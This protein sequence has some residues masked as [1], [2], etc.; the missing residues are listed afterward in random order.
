MVQMLRG[1]RGGSV[2]LKLYLAII[3]IAGGGGKAPFDTSIPARAWAELLDLPDPER[4]GARRVTDAIAWLDARTMI[5]TVPQPGRPGRIILLHESGGG[6]PYPGH[7]GT[8]DDPYI[9]LPSEFWE[10]G[11]AAVLSGTAIAMLLLVL[12]WGGEERPA[13][14]SPDMA[15]RHYALS[16]DSR[17]A[18]VAELRR[19]RLIT[20]GRQLVRPDLGVS[21]MRNTYA[22]DLDRLREAPGS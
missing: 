22:A 7:P 21:R 15:A 17:T 1:G 10:Y 11:W 8:R 19:H 14:I 5:Q 16:E 4:N 18:G 2:R 12:D 6:R 20:V 9:R 3:W 13:W